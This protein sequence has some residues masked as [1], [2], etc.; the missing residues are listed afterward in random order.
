MLRVMLRKNELQIQMI[1]PLFSAMSRPNTQLSLNRSQHSSED[2]I[3]HL[4]LPDFWPMFRIAD[5]VGRWAY[6]DG[7]RRRWTLFCSLVVMRRARPARG[8]P[9]QEIGPQL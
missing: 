4:P 8:T 9:T 5:D 3:F 2:P 7:P 6:R 1:S